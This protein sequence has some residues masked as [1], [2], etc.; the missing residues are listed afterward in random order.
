MEPSFLLPLLLSVSCPL[1]LM[2]NINNMVT[3][4]LKKLSSVT[5]G[6]KPRRTTLTLY[7]LYVES[8]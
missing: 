8:I 2:G 3:H 1:R 4:P 7:I 5:S 6:Q